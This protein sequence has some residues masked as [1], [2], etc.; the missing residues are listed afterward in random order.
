M[1]GNPPI[2][3]TPAQLSDQT[4]VPAGTLRVWNARHGFPAG[5][6]ERADRRRRFAETDVEAVRTVQ[7][8]REG[9][10]SLA[11]AIAQLQ[12][13]ATAPESSIYAALRRRRPD[14]RP[15]VMM[16]RALLQLSHAIED[17]HS[18]RAGSGLLLGSFQS[19]RHYRASRR[20]WRGLS[21]TV[22]C[23]IALA[24]F[25][26]L[27]EPAGGP[28]EVPLPREHQLGRE[29]TLIVDSPEARACLSAWEIAEAH[30]TRDS[31]RRFEVMWSFEPAVV[32]DATTAARS[33]LGDIAPSAAAR[34]PA[35]SRPARGSDADLRFGVE[36]A[37]RA[38]AYLADDLSDR[39]Q[40]R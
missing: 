17:E 5:Q 12:S 8:L 11:G 15:F 19:E 7:R 1:A 23:A 10:M 21:R 31:E 16:K 14:V 40:S 22:A 4:G 39:P 30:A 24:D 27:R 35:E 32:A 20:R 13:A 26:S 36:L 9:G 18:A 25:T 28:L 34:I 33:L 2:Y 38:Y 3:L 6:R 37:N 29:W